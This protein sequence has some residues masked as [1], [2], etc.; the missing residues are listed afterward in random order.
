MSIR[1]SVEQAEALE[2]V[3]SVE[4]LPLSE[5]IRTAINEHIESKTKESA[6][7]DSLRD[8]LAKAQRLLRPGS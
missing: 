3:A 8:R 2:I 4:S 7:Q 5:V 1:L 6:F